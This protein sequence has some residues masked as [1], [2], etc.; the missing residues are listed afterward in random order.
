MQ[1]AMIDRL[2]NFTAA[3]HDMEQLIAMSAQAKSLSAEYDAQQ[4]DRP[5]WLREATMAI[6]SEIKE[7]T[8][9]EMQRRLTTAKARLETLKTPDEKR[10]DTQREIER[11]QAALGIGSTKEAGV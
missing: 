3:Q 6:S 8:R 1:M 7:R 10:A 4:V 2:K 11:L 9:D 5:A